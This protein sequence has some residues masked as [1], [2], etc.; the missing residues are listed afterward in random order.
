MDAAGKE[1][2][3]G[4]QIL[5]VDHHRQA[6]VPALQ[7][8][9]VDHRQVVAA[10]VRVEVGQVVDLHVRVVRLKLAVAAL[11]GEESDAKAM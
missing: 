3:A 2:E 6:L 5:V 9:E 11:R 8:L 10:Q 7:V 4:L 1:A